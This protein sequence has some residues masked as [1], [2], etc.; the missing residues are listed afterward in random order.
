M[1]LQ[2]AHIVQQFRLRFYRSNA[3]EN[4]LP[5]QTVYVIDKMPGMFHF[6]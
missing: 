6:V 5:I 1:V 2:N 4:N 3:H